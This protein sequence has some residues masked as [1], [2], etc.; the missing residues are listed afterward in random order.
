MGCDIHLVIETPINQETPA[1]DHTGGWRFIHDFPYV[2]RGMFSGFDDS[3]EDGPR[4]LWFRARARH[5]DFFAALAG[6]RGE[7]RVPKGVPPGVAP[8]TRELLD[9][10]GGDGHS[11]TWYYGHEFAAIWGSLDTAKADYAAARLRGEVREEP[12]ANYENRAGY[13]SPYHVWCGRQ[14]LG[15]DLDCRVIIWFDN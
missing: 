1:K 13:S 4:G 7:G 12:P 2:E 15:T 6:V 11:H 10:W 14:L 9:S 8:H 3:P 5:Y